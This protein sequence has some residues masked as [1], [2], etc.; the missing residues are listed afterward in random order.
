MEYETWLRVRAE[1]A[2]LFEEIAQSHSVGFPRD[3]SNIFTRRYHEY[4][5]REELAKG[6]LVMILCMALGDIRSHQDS[7]PLNHDPECYAAIK[8]FRSQDR[9]EMRL[10]ETVLMALEI[11]SETDF[12]SRE[13]HRK[14]GQLMSMLPWVREHIILE[15]FRLLASGSTATSTKQ[16]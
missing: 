14:H 4:L 5:D 2:L 11:I 8:T 3:F 1:F 12:H 6:S 13:S 7:Y 16:P 9:S 15:R 10:A